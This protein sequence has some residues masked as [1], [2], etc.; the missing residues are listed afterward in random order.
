M[1]ISDWS[2]DVC[3]SDLLRSTEFASHVAMLRANMR[4]AGVLR[5][6]HVM[7]LER[8]FC[9]PAGGKPGDGAYLAYPSQAMRGLLAI[10]SRRNGCMV[11]GEDLGTVPEGF[12]ATMANTGILSYKLRSEEHTSE[13]QS[14]MRSSYA[15]FCLKNKNET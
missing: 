12:R 4:H 9:I 2:S 14:L 10:E 13:H 15:V 7:G 6:D 11:I 1:R 8:L 5:I 3:S